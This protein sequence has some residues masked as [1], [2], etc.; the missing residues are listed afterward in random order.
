MDFMAREDVRQE[1]ATLGVDPNEAARRTASLSDDEIRQ[2]AGR[3]DELPAGQDW[4]TGLVTGVGFLAVVYI[5]ALVA[6][7]YGVWWVISKL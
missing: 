4:N 2:I 3:L 7:I 5:I 6:I 1:L